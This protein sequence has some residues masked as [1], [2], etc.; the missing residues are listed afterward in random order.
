[1]YA[2]SAIAVNVINKAKV[3]TGLTKEY[4]F[5]ADQNQTIASPICVGYATTGRWSIMNFA[6]P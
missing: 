3:D 4:V 1:M 2:P 6:N 5:I